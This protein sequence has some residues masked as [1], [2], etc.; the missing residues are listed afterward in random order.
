MSSREDLDKL[1]QSYPFLYLKPIRGKAGKGIMRISRM[2]GQAAKA[3]QYELSIQDRTRSQISRFSSVSQLWSR[4][5]H[6]VG[7]K[8]YIIQQ[9]IALS[10]YK[11]R[12]F[13]LRLLAQKNHKGVWSIAGVGARLAGKNSITTHVPRGGSIDDPGKL[14]SHSFGPAGSKQIMQ[15]AKQAALTI[16]KQIESSSGYKLGEM[17]MD[18]GVD[19][20]GHIWFFEANSKPMK[21]DEPP[22]RQKSLEN[23]IRYSIF[24][25]KKNIRFGS[26]R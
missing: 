19:S 18:L 3:N 9:G 4:V 13:D 25:S 17:S 12:P 14:L 2:D 8:D 11:Q 6:L 16:A 21:F 23:L 26:K 24:L 22:I 15:R 10:H 7:S 1:L 20:D 5:S